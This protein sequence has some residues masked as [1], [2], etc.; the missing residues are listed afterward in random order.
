MSVVTGALG[1]ISSKLLQLLHDEYKLQK[2]VKK[3]VLWLSNELES[4]HAFLGK[5]AYVLDY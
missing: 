1:S 3:Q 5:I 4:V 2:G